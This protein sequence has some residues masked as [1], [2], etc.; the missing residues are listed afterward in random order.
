MIS[1][2]TS[3]GEGQ[4]QQKIEKQESKLDASTK[5]NFTCFEE[6][7]CSDSFVLAVNSAG[8]FPNYCTGVLSDDSHMVVPSRCLENAQCSDIAAKTTSGEIHKCKNI[9]NESHSI[10]KGL[11]FNGDFAV[12]ELDR[13]VRGDLSE[14]SAAKMSDFNYYQIW[15]I[16]KKLGTTGYELRNMR[17][18]CNK[19]IDNVIF[20]SN[21]YDSSVIAMKNCNLRN[22]SMGAAVVDSHSGEILGLVHD[23]IVEDKTY[24]RFMHG[25]RGETLT[26]ATPIRCILNE[27]D[28]V[29]RPFKNTPDYCNQPVFRP[30]TEEFS[31]QLRSLF[32]FSQYRKVKHVFTRETYE[33]S[34][35]SK[36]RDFYAVEIFKRTYGYPE[37]KICRFNPFLNRSFEVYGGD[38]TLGCYDVSMDVVYHEGRSERSFSIYDEF[39]NIALKVNY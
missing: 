39:G 22:E 2:G 36:R 19:T 25:R 3:G 32:I 29:S 28:S 8:D 12:V 4:Q 34:K 11:T 1:C 16:R 6:G 33:S 5:V 13:P 24:R 7:K 10:D 35:G 31:K 26:L 27:F 15:Y 9:Q 17:Y 21:N 38:Y 30:G 18:F 20:P 23:S 37:V 14:I